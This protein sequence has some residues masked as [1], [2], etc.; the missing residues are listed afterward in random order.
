MTSHQTP[1]Q[2]TPPSDTPATSPVEWVE[3]WNGD[4]IPVTPLSPAA[5]RGCGVV[6]HGEDLLFGRCEGCDELAP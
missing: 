4:R 2:P 5:C 6:Y 3:Q 1:S